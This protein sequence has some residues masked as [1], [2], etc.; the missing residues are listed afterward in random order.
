M[1]LKWD[2]IREFFVM[3]EDDID[4][5]FDTIPPEVII[6]LGRRPCCPTKIAVTTT[7]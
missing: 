2:R 1:S 6:F 7:R 3:L 5:L 4:A